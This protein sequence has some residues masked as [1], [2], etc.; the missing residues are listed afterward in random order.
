MKRAAMLYCANVDATRY[1][2]LK[3]RGHLPFL[4]TDDTENSK[5]ADFS[6]D[7][8]FRLRLSLDLI[9]GESTDKT[10]LNGL[11]PADAAKLVYNALAYFPRS[12]LNQIEPLDWWA[13]V[14]VFEDQ[15]EDGELFRWSAWYA[16][17]LECLNDWLMKKCEP[18]GNGGACGRVSVVRI[19]IANATRAASSVRQRAAELGL[20]EADDFSELVP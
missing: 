11:G 19:F 13:G 12:P 5:W 6:L 18:E 10:Q 14:A 7:D 8:A 20:P 3:Q 9:G 16:G 2:V 4:A 15:N 17:D 1:K